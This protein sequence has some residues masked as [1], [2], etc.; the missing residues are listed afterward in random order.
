M[1][2]SGADRWFDGGRLLRQWRVFNDSTHRVAYCLWKEFRSKAYFRMIRLFAANLLF[3]CATT[4]AFLP[5][6]ITRY[7][8]FGGISRFGAYTVLPWDWSAPHWRA[9]LLSSEHGL[10]TWTPVLLLSIAGLFCAP[11]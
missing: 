1:D 4:L 8:I 7:V 2:C 6:L 9:V 11:R 5:T 10:L 3:L